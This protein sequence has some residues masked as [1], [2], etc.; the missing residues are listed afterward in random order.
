MIEFGSD[1]ELDGGTGRLQLE[2]TAFVARFQQLMNAP[3]RREERFPEHAAKL[4]A[5]RCR[6][7]QS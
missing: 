5:D 3:N 4:S 6:R 2:G 1:E 7:V